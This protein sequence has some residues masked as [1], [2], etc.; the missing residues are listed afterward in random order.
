MPKACEHYNTALKLNPNHKGAHEYLGEV[1]L[2]NGKAA[3]AEEHLAH[4][5]TICGG[6]A[7]EEYDDLAKSLAAYKAKSR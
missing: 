2:M 5:K 6:N 3:K 7:C 1:C 4:L